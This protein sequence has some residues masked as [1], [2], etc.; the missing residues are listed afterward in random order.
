[1]A[2]RLLRERN[3]NRWIAVAWAAS[4]VLLGW[5]M[6]S[7]RPE[8]AVPSGMDKFVHFAVYLVMASA[9]YGFCRTR[10][11]LGVVA[12]LTLALSALFEYGQSFVPGRSFEAADLAANATGTLL[13]YLLAAGLLMRSARSPGHV[14]R[15]G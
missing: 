13:G 4:W 5:L 8:V 7:P 14:R 9:A 6:L 12:L 2:A 1:V 10:R 15:R 3:A 11:G